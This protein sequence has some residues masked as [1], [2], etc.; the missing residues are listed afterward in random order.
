MRTALVIAAVVLTT[1]SPAAMA[2]DGNPFDVILEA[3]YWDH[4][5]LAF[6]EAAYGMALETQ[7]PA[8]VLTVIDRAMSENA[9]PQLHQRDLL[10]I[11][12]LLTGTAGVKSPEEVRRI[13]GSSSICR[14]S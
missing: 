1:N 13:V 9:Y 5:C 12:R 10:V 6:K 11:G 7:D 3:R 2:A 8:D 14:K 4:E